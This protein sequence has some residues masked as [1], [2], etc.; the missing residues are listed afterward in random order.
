MRI[1]YLLLGGAGFFVLL[2]ILGVVFAIRARFQ[3]QDVATSGSNSQSIQ[4]ESAGSDDSSGDSGAASIGYTVLATADPGQTIFTQKSD[5]PTPQA[6]ILAALHDLT[7]ILDSK[8]TVLGAFADAQQHRRGGATFAGSLHSHPVKGT[9][10]CGIGD[11]GAAITILY[12]RAD[13][14]PADWAK[15]TAALPADTQMHEQPI[16]DGAGTISIPPDW[17]VT[18]SSNVGSVFIQGPNAQAISLGIGLEVVTPDSMGAAVQNQLAAA[19]QL[20]PATRMLVAPFTGPQQAP[21]NLSPQLSD[22]SQSRGGPAIILDRILQTI[23]VQP[24]LPSGQAA[25]IYYRTIHSLNGQAV[26]YLAWGQLECYPVGSGTWGIYSSVITGPE[27]SFDVDLPLMIE[28]AKSWKLNDTI[29]AQHTQQNIAAANARFAA[30]EQSMQEKQ[31]AFDA[32]L[33]SV[34][35]NE[36]IQDRSNADF[37][38]VIR[39]YRTVYDTSTGDKSSVDLGSVDGIV[40]ALNEG[41]PGR[42]VQIPLRDE[43]FPLSAGN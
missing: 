6:A 42:Y 8:P 26:P 28:I 15:L 4:S 7:R 38:E 35:H 10:I 12:D 3:D 31:D 14:P 22:M 11:K 33:K 39:G 2:I 13:A 17:K 27:S 9:I 19:G 23:P 29:V 24:E 36:L 20:T 43:E 34:Q 40:N 32:Y 30:F 18:D 21:Q 1:K 25:R 41:N 37:D 16:G 5:A